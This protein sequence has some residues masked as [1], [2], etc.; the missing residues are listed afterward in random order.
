MNSKFKIG[1]S[2]SGYDGGVS[3]LYPLRFKRMAV[4][5]P[6]AGNRL[7]RLFPAIGEEI[8]VG[9]GETIELADLP[10]YSSEIANRRH[11][12]TP[13]GL[14][15]APRR[16][17]LLGDADDGAADFPLAIKLLDTAQPLSIQVHP[18]DQRDGSRLVRRGKAE[19]WIILA[20]DDAA[21]IYQDLKPGVGRAGLEAALSAG[22]APDVMNARPVN[23]GDY[24]YNPAGTIHALGGGL[25]LFEVQ[26]NCAV[27]YRL[28]DFPREGEAGSAAREMHVAEGLAAARFDLA[29][30]PI[31][32]AREPGSVELQ[33]EG[34]FRVRSHR[35]TTAGPIEGG[36]GFAIFTCLEGGCELIAQGGGRLETI[37]LRAPE[38]V[39]VPAQ[40]SDFELYP[41]RSC[42]LIETRAAV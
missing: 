40:F 11:A 12:E 20:A 29:V 14:Y 6:W 36:R 34:P 7:R 31:K 8:P 33:S 32:S 16:A 17:E 21:V 19:A 10:D 35:L 42:W 18:S 27:T 41:D 1:N 37:K 2:K 3:E 9:T 25:T 30:Q 22:N 4:P 39:L 26:Q 38:T 24:L 28:F 15:L 13:L 5:K 23:R